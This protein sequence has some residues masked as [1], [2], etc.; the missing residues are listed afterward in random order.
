MYD[1]DN[2]CSLFANRSLSCVWMKTAKPYLH[3]LHPF[4]PLFALHFFVCRL[5]KWWEGL[6]R[7]HQVAVYRINAPN[8]RVAMQ[9]WEKLVLWKISFIIIKAMENVKCTNTLP[10]W[11]PTYYFGASWDVCLCYGGMV[12]NI[13]PSH[14]QQRANWRLTKIKIQ[15]RDLSFKAVEISDGKHLAVL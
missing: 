14:Y 6:A 12:S 5:R 3:G 10:S 2:D 1:H 8:Y 7:F 9:L 11:L 4:N 13:F 15:L